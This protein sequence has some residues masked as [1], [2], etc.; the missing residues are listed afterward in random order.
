MKYKTKYNWRLT[1]IY[2]NTPIK[3]VL[4]DKRVDLVLG[5]RLIDEYIFYRIDL[6][7]VYPNYFISYCGLYN[8]TKNE[9]TIHALGHKEVIASISRFVELDGHSFIVHD[10]EECERYID[11]VCKSNNIMINDTI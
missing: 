5:N 4:R 7:K 2:G 10:M 3:P 8:P 9:L 6:K 1:D 11:L